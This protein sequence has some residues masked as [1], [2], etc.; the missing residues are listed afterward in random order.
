MITTPSSE[1][2]VGSIHSL[3]M[4]EIST[5]QPEHHSSS[6]P[7]GGAQPSPSRVTYPQP[8]VEQ[9]SHRP[10]HQHNF[11]PP[12][13]AFPG[14]NTESWYTTDEH[15]SKPENVDPLSS[16]HTQ[17]GNIQLDDMLTS[18]PQDAMFFYRP[19]FQP[20]VGEQSDMQMIGDWK[21]P[22]V[23]TYSCEVSMNEAGSEDYHAILE[24]FSELQR[25]G[26]LLAQRRYSLTADGDQEHLRVIMDTL[27]KM[28]DKIC[29]MPKQSS[30]EMM[31]PKHQSLAFL[32]FATVVQAV[33]N[34]GR[35]AELDGKP[36]PPQIPPSLTR[37]LCTGQPDYHHNT[38]SPNNPSPRSFSS[39]DG[40]WAAGSSSS[41][42][43]ELTITVTRLDYFLGQLES[44]ISAFSSLVT[45]I[46]ISHPDELIGKLQTLHHRIGVVLEKLRTGST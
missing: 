32:V 43:L 34:I 21:S 11:T 33:D 35:F 5:E 13:E 6:I 24:V 27:R 38:R 26:N 39:V 3:D 8:I 23:N 2:H 29:A 7:G 16:I 1:S 25:Q 41:S 4:Q 31:Q 18:F 36:P 45:V 19:H 37:S 30:A 42:R 28:S 14:E 46:T 40:S 9:Q 22:P 10:Y 12:Y 17:R 15:Q 20:P 44:F